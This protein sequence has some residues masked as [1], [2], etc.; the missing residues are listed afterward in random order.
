MTTLVNCQA[1]PLIL[2]THETTK[3]WKMKRNGFDNRHTG[4]SFAVHHL[5]P[6]KDCPD[7]YVELV[8]LPLTIRIAQNE[9]KKKDFLLAPP[10][11]HRTAHCIVSIKKESQQNLVD[12]TLVGMK[13]EL[14]YVSA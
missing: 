11:Y 5:S 10:R 1:R 4:K 7:K 9:S 3:G 14:N 13:C 2:R 12:N 6:R 8:E